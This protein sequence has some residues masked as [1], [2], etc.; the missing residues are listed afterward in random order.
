VR[1]E[2]AVCWAGRAEK[3][4]GSGWT[5]GKGKE[6]GPCGGV[7]GKGPGSFGPDGL[8]AGFGLVSFSF[9]FSILF[10]NTSNLFEFKFNLNSTLTLK[11]IKEMLQHECNKYF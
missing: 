9:H 7:K 6:S 11:Q 10:L 3:E 4:E 5:R 1:E 8:R 2:R